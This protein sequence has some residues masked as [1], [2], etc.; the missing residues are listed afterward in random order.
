MTDSFKQPNYTSYVKYFNNGANP[1][2][3]NVWTTT[4]YNNVPVVTPSNKNASVYIPNDLYVGG[5]INNPSDISL[6]ENIKNIDVKLANDLLR[7]SPKRYNY[8]GDKLKRIHYGL[9]AQEIE[10]YYPELVGDMDI[11]ESMDFTTGS[12]SNP[13]HNTTH[14]PQHNRNNNNNGDNNDDG[15]KNRNNN[16]NNNGDNGDNG[17]NNNNRNWVWSILSAVKTMFGMCKK[18]IQTKKIKTINYIELIPILVLKIQ[19]LQGQIDDIKN[20]NYLMV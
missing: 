2:F 7:L 9:I 4:Q 8:K 15:D 13:Q 11:E 5:S 12:V 18:N 14:N 6:K 17:D 16:N 10:D 19:D 3:L 1:Q 20:G